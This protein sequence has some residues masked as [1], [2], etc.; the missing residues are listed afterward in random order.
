MSI[1]QLRKIFAME[2]ED[3][4]QQM[5]DALLNL[6]KSADN[7]EAVNV[8]F[9]VA[10][11]LKGSAAI[12]G[13]DDIS[14]F[15]HMMENILDRVRSGDLAVNPNLIQ[16]MLA[17]HDH[18]VI[19][20]EHDIE[21]P[22]TKQPEL[23][24][25]TQDLKARLQ[26]L[27]NTPK[28]PPVPQVE[29]PPVPQ[30]EHPQPVVIPEEIINSPPVVEGTALVITTKPIPNLEITA[31]TLTQAPHWQLSLRFHEDALRNGVDP[32]AV[33][34]YLEE[35]GQIL[36]I[37]TL[38][39]SMPNATLMNPEHCYLG[40]EIA[41]QI[42]VDPSAVEGMFDLVRDYCEVRIVPPH[43]SINAYFRTLRHLP[44]PIERIGQI[45]R[46]QHTLT[47]E[48]WQCGVQSEIPADEV[49]MLSSAEPPPVPPPSTV[50]PL[51][52]HN[53]SPSS[54]VKEIKAKAQKNLQV[55]AE[56]LDQLINLV[57]ELVIANASIS[58][59]MQKGKYDRLGESISTM[60]RLVEEIRNSTL[61]MRM[62]HIGNT[63]SRFQRMVHDLSRDLGKEIELVISGAE[64][65]LDKSMVEKINDPL[66]HL[67]RNSIDHGIEKPDIRLAHSK[68]PHG[69]LQLNAYHDSGMVVIEVG[70]DGKGLD[71]QKLLHKAMQKGIIRPDQEL[72]EQ[73]VDLLMFEPGISTSEAVTELS[74]RG[75]GLDV[76]KRNVNALNGTIDVFS[77]ENE[78]TQVRIC[79]PLT[80][81]IID[82][83]LFNVGKSSFVV[84]LDRVVECVELP[85][86]HLENKEN[87]Y[88]NLRG[89]MLPLVYLHQLFQLEGSQTEEIAC[90]NIVVVR[91]G[92]REAGLVVSS[93]FG[94]FQA[95]IKPLGK[96]FERLH[97]ISGATILGSGDVALILDVPAL[98]RHYASLD[99]SDSSMRRYSVQHLIT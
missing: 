18:L 43:S 46:A 27:I 66:M 10:H 14:A 57:G 65:E 47:H 5:E 71:R 37:H 68:T 19:W 22:D 40:L 51:P 24:S 26:S 64:T 2:S 28:T 20:I 21:Q 67:V 36:C 15:T 48:E 90:S 92:D 85:Q 79:L 88:L 16:V 8:V 49:V 7:H 95:V 76:V 86:E 32:L 63:F 23:Q 29:H 73:E 3:T 11:T 58:L 91:Y 83:F 54:P 9:R 52:A 13:L 78:G 84:P 30:V 41:Y 50:V 99:S 80:L 53:S 82:G 17:C 42:N 60:S 81:A 70:D 4:L 35:Q 98:V 56:K 62:V 55:D 44:E 96:L 1:Q 72:T 77:Q 93:L 74:G 89:R 87:N 33:I 38:F 61:R 39:D 12:V 6:E 59:L 69:T 25:V 75:V 31:D 45:W 34:R 94:E 97:G